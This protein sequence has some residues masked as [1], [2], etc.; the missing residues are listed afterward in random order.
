MI[1]ITFRH[2]FRKYV[3]E[4]LN[5]SIKI[6]GGARSHTTYPRGAIQFSGGQMPPP[7]PLNVILTIAQ[8][9]VKITEPL[10]LMHTQ[11]SQIVNSRICIMKFGKF[12]IVQ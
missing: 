5:Q 7:A 1:V 12:K 4:G 8:Q 10:L 6:S 9:M 3:K 11:I 2:A